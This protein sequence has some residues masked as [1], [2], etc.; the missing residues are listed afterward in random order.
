[1]L[2]WRQVSDPLVATQQQGL[3]VPSV[4]DSCPR[5]SS[6][7]LA[8][9]PGSSPSP[10]RTP[11][12]GSIWTE[13]EHVRPNCKR[14]NLLLLKLQTYEFPGPS[15]VYASSWLQ[16]L[17]VGGVLWPMSCQGLEPSL[18]TL[19]PLWR[20]PSGITENDVWT[21]RVLSCLSTGLSYGLN[22]VWLAS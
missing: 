8:T 17:P 22:T 5:P 16:N 13:S 15:K 21:P 19:A 3:Q 10:L 9:G 11:A 12:R 2:Q 4:C 1:M 14:A 7:P 6:E 20:T 18:L